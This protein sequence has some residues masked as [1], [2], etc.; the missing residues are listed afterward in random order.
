M[1]GT[2]IMIGLEIELKHFIAHFPPL[3]FPLK[4]RSTAYRQFAHGT[5][6]ND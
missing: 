3:N 6:K 2:F 1:H 5:M 4:H